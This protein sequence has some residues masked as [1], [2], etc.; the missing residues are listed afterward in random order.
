MKKPTAYRLRQ[1]WLAELHKVWVKHGGGETD[2]YTAQDVWDA[3]RNRFP[4]GSIDKD[5][6]DRVLRSLMADNSME[7]VGEGDV[8]GI[9]LTD[10][11]R[12]RFESNRELRR[13]TWVAVTGAVTGILAL[14]VS[15]ASELI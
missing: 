4:D 15:V 2:Y 14:I 12:A 8:V 1:L 11:G 3:V 7:A 5:L 6:G 9:R 13:N 10:V